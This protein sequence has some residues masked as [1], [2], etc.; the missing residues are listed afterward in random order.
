M[1]AAIEKHCANLSNVPTITLSKNLGPTHK[2]EP[3]FLRMDI[4][5]FTGIQLLYLSYMVSFK[6]TG[7]AEEQ[8]I[9]PC[10]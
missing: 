6:D 2:P 3:V 9:T 4:Y 8:W 5:V 1:F 10:R 7:I